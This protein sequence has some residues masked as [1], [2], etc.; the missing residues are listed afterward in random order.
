MI[1]SPLHPCPFPRFQFSHSLVPSY[2]FD[3]FFHPRD[4]SLWVQ[5][6]RIRLSALITGSSFASFAHSLPPTGYFIPSTAKFCNCFLFHAFLFSLPQREVWSGLITKVWGVISVRWWWSGCSP[7]SWSRQRRHR[8]R[9]FRRRRRRLASPPCPPFLV[10]SLLLVLLLPCVNP[11]WGRGPLYGSQLSIHSSVWCHQVLLGWRGTIWITKK[12]KDN[13][14]L[15]P[16]HTLVGVKL[17]R[18][19]TIACERCSAVSGT[20]MAMLNFL[21]LEFERPKESLTYISII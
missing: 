2:P 9:A 5:T 10:R 7:S 8:T 16:S 20:P 17:L 15:R 4:I 18:E 11:D 6:G 13:L 21:H 19:R 14:V 3:S 1:I 12:Y